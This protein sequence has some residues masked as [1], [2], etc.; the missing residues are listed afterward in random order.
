MAKII[1]H[2]T[3]G[4]AL[5]SIVE[6]K[7]IRFSDIRCM[8]DY[9]E[10]SLFV[11]AIIKEAALEPFK[12][13][14]RPEIYETYE[15]EVVNQIEMKMAEQRCFI[16]SCSLNE[17]SLPM[18]NYYSKGDNYGGYNIGLN[19]VEVIKYIYKNVIEK[20]EGS[21]I[22]FGKVAYC[23]SD[24]IVRTCLN[25]VFKCGMGALNELPDE[26]KVKIENE[27]ISYL[28]QAVNNSVIDKF[29]MENDKAQEY[30]EKWR[31][32][33]REYLNECQN[34]DLK[35]NKIV[36]SLYRNDKIEKDYFNINN[37]IKTGDFAYEKEF[38]IAIIIPTDK[39]NKINDF[40]NDTK[41]YK[42]RYQNGMYIPYLEM[43]IPPAAF[44]SI[45]I[46]PTNFTLKPEKNLSEFLTHNG[47]N[48][49]VS[50]SDITVRY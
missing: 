47:I 24:D 7:K 28:Y 2:Y 33:W 39:V 14:I 9:G 42:T 29:K 8:N 1:Y 46:A 17:D 35:K 4:N 31:E 43:E 18:W 32:S 10:Q 36:V 49:V 13:I 12:D 21:T 6:D 16:L 40:L 50:K 19:I 27:I 3:S 26:T 45:R 37:F 34:V 11:Q 30:V 15:K 5:K 41:P 48:A 23:N 25:N 38:R 22:L 44:D 20:I